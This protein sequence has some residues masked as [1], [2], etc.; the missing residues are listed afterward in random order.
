MLKR[1][2][3]FYIVTYYINWSRLLGHTVYIRRERIEVNLAPCKIYVLKRKVAK[4][5]FFCGPS[6]KALLHPPLEFTGQVFWEILF[7]DSK[8]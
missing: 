5:F 7:T 2:D 3:P 8:K 1:L 4:K 6:T